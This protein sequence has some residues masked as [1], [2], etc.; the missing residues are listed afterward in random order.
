[1]Q[2][3]LIIFSIITIL[4][5]IFFFT[6]TAPQVEVKPDISIS[7]IKAPGK[8]LLDDKIP[9]KIADRGYIPN[10]LSEWN[11]SL[12]FILGFI[13]AIFLGSWF[14]RRMTTKHLVAIILSSTIVAYFVEGWAPHAK[15][16]TYLHEKNLI[17]NSTYFIGSES[18]GLHVPPL[19]PLFV[20][21]IF[22]L[23]I[24]GISLLLCPV[25][26]GI[27]QKRR[28]FRLVPYSVVML[29]LFAFLLLEG[30]LTSAPA[31]MTVIYA[32][33]ALL[34]LYFNEK[35]SLDF[36]LALVIVA[37]VLGFTM[38]YLVAL[39]GYWGYPLTHGLNSTLLSN[40]TEITYVE[41]AKRQFTWLP[42]FV[43]FTWALNTWAACGL[44]Q[45][46][47]IDINKSF[48]KDE[49]FDTENPQ[50]WS[51]RGDYLFDQGD[52]E[53]AIKHYE[54]AIE[55]D[56]KMAD[57][58]YG[59]G[60]VLASKG[61]FK[62]SERAY[63]R[64]ISLYSESQQESSGVQIAQ[65]LYRKAITIHSL[66]G[67]LEAIKAYDEALRASERALKSKSEAIDTYVQVWADKALALQELGK[68]EE[69]FEQY[70]NAIKAVKNSKASPQE[71]SQKQAQLLIFLGFA[72]IYDPYSGTPE[73]PSAQGLD[74]RDA[75]NPHKE[76][77]VDFD[78]AMRRMPRYADK[79]WLAGAYWGRGYANARLRNYGDALEDFQKITELNFSI[80]PFILNDKGD[81]LF[82][83][84]E[85]YRE[86][87]EFVEKAKRSFNDALEVYESAIQLYP[88]L[89]Y[90]L[91][92]PALW[93]RGDLLS[94]TLAK[95]WEGKGDAH[96]RIAEYLRMAVDWIEE[97]NV[98][99]EKGEDANALDA[100]K[101]AIKL[102]P[103]HFPANILSKINNSS[104]D[105]K[106]LRKL[107]SKSKKT[108]DADLGEAEGN[109][110][111]AYERSVSVLNRLPQDIDAKSGKG[112]IL[113]KMTRY[114]EAHKAYK[115]AIKLAE[116]VDKPST[117]NKISLA[118]AK[119][120][121]GNVLTKS[122]KYDEALKYYT[123]AISEVPHY[124][125][126]TLC[127]GCTYVLMGRCEDAEVAF[128]TALETAPEGWPFEKELEQ[129][130]K[131]IGAKKPG[132]KNL[133]YE[134]AWDMKGRYAEVWQN[135]GGHLCLLREMSKD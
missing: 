82:D 18:A 3:N 85:Y 4:S 126:A 71:K 118:K 10:G 9:K 8:Y 14:A 17:Y 130:I 92:S 76:A 64:A 6:S 131:D 108:L 35:Q 53:E 89:A 34:G 52:Y 73:G 62:N 7:D 23:S 70:E 1:M 79:T 124:L 49:V 59:K 25:F 58:F 2:N 97:G 86:K 128:Q 38:E 98:L 46:F 48:V 45:I 135:R 37:V 41:L 39:A 120:G 84:G 116:G 111:K 102:Y 88:E 57:A 115:E 29:A 117:I 61:D 133:I 43:G 77:I 109:A 24:I 27:D 80:P 40:I 22:V 87:E 47:G 112:Y 125:P 105:L 60:N 68:F 69:S 67:P 123:E 26:S 129:I 51:G 74:P 11:K 36:N 56:P 107:V 103:E 99:S 101:K 95:A 121:L 21:P 100:Y 28:R 110:L 78:D 83:L 127:K 106:S 63:E 33:M 96:S 75:V 122:G 42:V 91:G 16:W 15:W 66:Q 93:S 94:I 44:A 134:T 5:L 132:T 113:L 55:M 104:I 54:K 90:I 81:V 32:T 12:A 114:R 31:Y 20:V 50:A 30:Y 72:K 119:T 65:A 13:L 19:F